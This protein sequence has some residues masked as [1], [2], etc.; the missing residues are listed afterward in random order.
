MIKICVFGDSVPW[1]AYDMERGGWVEMT[2][3]KQLEQ[4]RIV[5]NLGVSDDDSN[6]L[7][8]RIENEINSREPSVVIFHL[9]LND[10][11]SIGDQSNRVPLKKFASNLD[12]LSYILEK[13]TSVKYVVFIGLNPITE[14]D[15]IY[16]D[17]IIFKMG[18][19][20]RY[21]KQ[22]ESFCEGKRYKYLNISNVLNLKED[23]YQDG[24]HPN[25]TGHEKIFNLV[26]NY[27]DSIL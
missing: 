10:S 8:K 25:S 27:L 18:E 3:I 6:D 24:L 17:G 1:G 11:I 21:D 13:N 20:D 5:Y 14:K 4:D 22:I 2:K 9:G 19:I 23:I 26:N 15:L 7:L 16:R 12:K